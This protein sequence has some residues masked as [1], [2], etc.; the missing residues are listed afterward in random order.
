LVV[1][2]NV[3]DGSD[4]CGEVTAALLI[5]VTAALVHVNVVPATLLE[6]VYVKSVP[7]Q[8][9]DGDSGLDNEGF[10]FTVMVT[11][12]GAPVQFPD[13]GVTV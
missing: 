7:L 3:S 1:L 11:V 12:N 5:P 8:T 2:F 9:A 6:A 13:T 4:D 10:G